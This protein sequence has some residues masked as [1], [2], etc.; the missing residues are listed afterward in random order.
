MKKLLNDGWSYLKLPLGST[1]DDANS[2]A[3]WV[4]VD[5]PHDWLIWQEKDLYESADAWYRRD[6][7]FDEVPEICL[8][9]FDGVYMDCDVLLNGSI[10]TSH[11]YGY[12][13]FYSDLTKALRAGKNEITVHIRH[14][15]PNSR[16][17]S[18]S[19]IFRDVHL[20][21]LPE[22]HIVPD[23][24]YLTEKEDGPDWLLRVSAEASKTDHVLFSCEVFDSQGKA[25]GNASTESENGKISLEFR[26]IGAPV[27]DVDSPELCTLRYTYGTDRGSVSFGLRTTEFTSDRGF[28]L[29]HRNIKL[30]GVC[31]HHD[32]GALGSAFSKKAARRQLMLMKDMGANAVR[33]SHN[34]PASA[35]LDLCDELG[36]LVIDEA[37]DMWERPKT[38]YDYA[39]FFPRHETEDVALWIRRD[40][41]HPSVIMWSVGNEI[42][43]MHADMRGTEVCTMLMNQVRSHDPREHA[44]V[45]FGC[46]YMPWEGGQRCADVVKVAGYNYGEKYYAEHHAKHPDW[47]IYGSETAS[48]LSS[49]GIYHFPMEQ[50]IMSE[51]DLQ[52][53]ALGNSNT[54][55]GALD[56]REMIVDDLKCPYS[57]GQFIWSG[58]DYIGEPTPY[59]TRSCYF[60]QA[61]TACFPKDPFYLFK[62]LWSGKEV[63]HIGVSWDWNPGQLIDVPVMTSYDRVELT[64]NGKSLG[65]KEVVHD[66]A[67]ACL[68]V[69]KVPYEPG[70]IR[71]LALDRDGNILNTD[72]R[73]TPGDTAELRMTS[74]DECLLSDGQDLAFITVQAFDG[75]GH[76]VENARDRVRVTI[77]GGAYLIGTDNGDSTDPDGYKSPC[78]RLFSGKLLLIAAS[79]GIQEDAR[80][81]IESTAGITAAFTVPV[82]AAPHADGTS[83][84]MRIPENAATTTVH[85]RKIE[86]APKNQPSGSSIVLT[87]ETPSCEFIWK[88]LPE[89]AH[90]G[91]VE[92]QMTNFAGIV[93]PFAKAEAEGNTVRV[94]ASGDGN[95]FLRALGGNAAD[96]PEIISQ[97]EILVQGMGCPALD[98]YGFI[99]A[100]LYDLHEGD[101]GTGNEKGIA[102]A[103]DGESMVGFSSVDFGKAGSD[104]LILP[105]FALDGK[106]YEIEL[107]DGDPR[108]GSK[109]I[110]VLKYEKPSIWNVY[111]EETYR[112]PV[113]LT[114]I[115]TLCFR[116][117][118]K[119]HMKGFSFERQERAFAM[120]AAGDADAVYGDSFT[121]SGSTVKD[122]GNNVSFTFDGM[123]FGDSRNCMLIIRGRTSLT[124]NSITVRIRDSKGNS[125]NEVAD[126]MGAG[127]EEQRF[128][129][130]VPGG[131]CSVTFVFLPG[132]CFDF[133]SFRFIPV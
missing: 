21:I 79:N 99:S 51:S 121:R 118:D 107:S 116:M 33:T 14:Q 9:H 75:T 15:S 23:S 114:G 29:N 132:S 6:L 106:P 84:R 58:T 111:Q 41:C 88:L 49:R 110:A 44:K 105:I 123:N 131:L 20:L 85:I 125:I 95:Y 3:D 55:W 104:T 30:K 46:N 108:S 78:R 56:L 18:G 25:V 27:W 61:D 77:S 81:R 52:C 91:P 38:P 63:L 17:Y 76:P 127:G 37:F 45:T 35:F 59:H 94:T 117:K 103:R 5:L 92:W 109:T 12:T 28:F 36:L 60:G 26:L 74:E 50:A 101:I 16:W 115:H 130:R 64:L 62:S 113:R 24:F 67:K 71:A 96:Y 19:G 129:V 1:L 7:F 31:L 34:P 82:K 122:I 124:I 11:A 133:E 39:R 13:A 100:G 97:V 42:Y 57:M 93:T 86:I 98:P 119:V 53:S 8:L 68:P 48:V 32:L 90:G 65:V 89:G 83:C 80:V 40:R 87:K 102:F 10:V 128:P 120:L 22:N 70:E 47:I 4:P 73:Y 43:D 54:S 72:T 69:W 66:D 126:F 112:L 2:S